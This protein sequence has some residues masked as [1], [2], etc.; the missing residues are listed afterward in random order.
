MMGTEGVTAIED[1]RER[2]LFRY[3]ARHQGKHVCLLS[4]YQSD[5]GIEVVA[6]IH[7]VSALPGQE[8]TNRRLRFAS[9]DQA[10]RF[11]DELLTSLEYLD[12]SVL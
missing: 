11:V 3:E 2:A 7:S 10:R 12:C 5:T 4:G 8:A 1:G 6:E 9:D